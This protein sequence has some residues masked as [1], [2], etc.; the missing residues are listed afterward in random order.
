MNKQRKTLLEEIKNELKRQNA[1]AGEICTE[2]LKLERK[3]IDGLVYYLEG[4]K[5]E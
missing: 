2:L 3:S 5:N 1:T 4:L